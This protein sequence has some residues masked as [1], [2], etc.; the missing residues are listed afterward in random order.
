MISY[1][2]L[3]AMWQTAAFWLIGAMS[4]DTNKLAIYAGFYECFEFL[5]FAFPQGSPHPGVRV[6]SMVNPCAD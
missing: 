5:S 6:I 3:D 2:L 4:N 1:G